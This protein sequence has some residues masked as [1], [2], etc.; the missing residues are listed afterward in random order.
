MTKIQRLY[1]AAQRARAAYVNDKARHE[2]LLANLTASLGELADGIQAAE[3][4]SITY[5]RDTVLRTLEHET[6]GLMVR[7]ARPAPLPRLSLVHSPR[8]LPSLALPSIDSSPLSLPSLSPHPLPV[9]AHG[10]RSMC[11]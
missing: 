1:D 8:A 11:A 9:P 2:Q 10:L 5:G 3:E 6:D 4:E 7:T